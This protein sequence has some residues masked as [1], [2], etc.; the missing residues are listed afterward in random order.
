MKTYKLRNGPDGELIAIETTFDTGHGI[1]QI[2]MPLNP[3]L[4]DYQEYLKWLAE[5]NT[6]E[7]ADQGE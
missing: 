5:G 6:P 3:D 2:S 4:P 1:G 7:P